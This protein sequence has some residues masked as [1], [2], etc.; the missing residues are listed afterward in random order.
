MSEWDEFAAEHGPWL[1]RRAWRI[2]HNHH[3]AEDVTQDV[4]IEEFQRRSRNKQPLG[5]P[6]LSRML[7]FRAIDCLRVRR[8]SVTVNGIEIADM[9]HTDPI[10]A[11]SC[12]ELAELLR[13]AIST[14]P[15]REATAFAL[16]HLEGLSYA[17]IAVVLDISLTAV[18]TALHKARSRL[19]SKLLSYS[20]SQNNAS[21]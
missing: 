6:L 2:L 12:N 20:R 9:R 21:R 16:R 4:L 17:E 18:S 11:A 14:L 1:F 3:D 10:E 7:T 19:Q 13:Q 5:M 15:S 8:T